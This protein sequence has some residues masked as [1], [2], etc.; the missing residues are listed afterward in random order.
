MKTETRKARDILA[1]FPIELSG[2]DE[3]LVLEASDEAITLTQSLAI[4][5]YARNRPNDVRV[6]RRGTLRD[7]L[8]AL[9]ITVEKGYKWVAR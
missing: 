7:M 8:N 2:T 3:R 4:E 9:K 5:D 1:Q 6:E